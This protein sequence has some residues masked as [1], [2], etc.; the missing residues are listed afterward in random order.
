MI[1]VRTLVNSCNICKG[2]IYVSTMKKAFADNLKAS[3]IKSGLSQVKL[4]EI[5]SYSGKAISKWESGTALPPAEMLPTLAQAL[6]TDLNSL[7]SFH[8]KPSFFLGI[9]G[10]G[11]KTGFMLTDINGNVLKTLILA[12]SNPSVIGAEGTAEIIKS[13]IKELCKDIPLGKISIYAG[14]AGCGTPKFRDEVMK[15]FENYRF[16]SFCISGDAENIISAAL[17]KNDGVIAILGTGSI[18]YSCIGEK[19]HRIGGYGHIIGDVCSG[20]EFGRSCISAV[21]DDLDTSGPHTIMTEMLKERSK[22]DINDLLH[23]VYNNGKDFTASFAGIVFEA[24][25]KGDTVAEE[26]IHKNAKKIAE[27]LVAALNFFPPYKSSVPIYLA[28][29]IAGHFPYLVD[30][31]NQYITDERLSKINTL[32]C[33]PVEGAVLLAGAPCVIKS[34]KGE[35]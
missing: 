33:E 27:K 21:L 7:F 35:N 11:T 9:D 22:C 32:S 14:I 34:E 18:I 19:R 24:A 25:E 10:G 5:L 8:E 6:D 3:R 31:I 12:G 26:V 28:G 17:G 16:S 29:G 1:V 4:A 15:Q 30:T 2:V 23:E 20:T 13:G